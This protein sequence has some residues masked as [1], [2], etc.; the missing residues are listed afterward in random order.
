M[1]ELSVDQARKMLVKMSDTIVENEPYLT[2]IDTIIGDGDRGFGSLGKLMSASTYG[3]FRELFRA[4]GMELVKTMGGAS[5]VL[6]GTLFIG[7]IGGLADD[8]HIGLDGLAEFIAGGGGAVLKRGRAI[9]G[10]KTMV[11]ALVP[12]MESLNSSAAKGLPLAKAME[13]A[14]EAAYNGAEAT[15]AMTPGIGRAKNFGE[16]TLGYPDPGAVSVSLLF[17]AMYEFVK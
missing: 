11:D 14:Y 7:G 10:Q 12:A 9:P 16:K 17:K 2:E 3:S 8:K 5:G 6:F 13:L 4:A 1:N 15:K